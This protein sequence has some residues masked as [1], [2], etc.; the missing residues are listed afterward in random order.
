MFNL[1]SGHIFNVEVITT[2]H[3]DVHEHPSVPV[4]VTVVYDFHFSRQAI[5]AKAFQQ[6]QL[7]FLQPFRFLTDVHRLDDMC[8]HISIVSN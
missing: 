1:A 8:V 3:N 6:S 5:Y 7:N 4:V 2:M